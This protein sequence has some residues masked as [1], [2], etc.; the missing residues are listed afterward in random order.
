[1]T[2][3][4][5]STIANSQSFRVSVKLVTNQCR[6]HQLENYKKECHL[7]HISSGINTSGIKPT[8]VHC[9]LH[10]HENMKDL[11]SSSLAR[12]NVKKIP[13]CH[14]YAKCSKINVSKTYQSFNKLCVAQCWSSK[15]NPAMEAPR[16][17]LK[18]PYFQIGFSRHL[19]CRNNY[20]WA[21][22]WVWIKKRTKKIKNKKRERKE[23]KLH[24][25]L[26]CMGSTRIHLWRFTC[27]QV[28]T[29]LTIR[30]DQN[31]LSLSL[32]LLTP[33]FCF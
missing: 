32:D 14:L 1:M 2:I 25:S 22:A 18:K 9:C 28:I 23:R 19:H 20:Y 27:D 24:I 4:K 10:I 30:S 16:D 29:A 15:K 3:K 5:T 7:A 31:H 21:A 13:Y 26:H 17:R 11:K 12:M 33:I 8:H 6:T